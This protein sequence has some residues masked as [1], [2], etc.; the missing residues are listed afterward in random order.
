MTSGVA[1]SSLWT[2]TDAR[3]HRLGVE[4]E[5]SQHILEDLL[6]VFV[7]GT[8]DQMNAASDHT[9]ETNT[10]AHRA[11]HGCPRSAMAMTSRLE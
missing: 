3:R 8:I 9:P 4:V 6:I 10:K 2:T 5:I 7:H 11:R 1:S